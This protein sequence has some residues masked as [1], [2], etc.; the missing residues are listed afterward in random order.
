MKQSF[1][2]PTRRVNTYTIDSELVIGFIQQRCNNA[3][4]L[5]KIAAAVESMQEALK[6]EP[7]ANPASTLKQVLMHASCEAQTKVSSL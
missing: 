1:R 4:D 2:L 7:L 5:C 6:E 3:D